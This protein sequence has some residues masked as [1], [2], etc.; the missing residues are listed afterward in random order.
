MD[1]TERYTT[2]SGR[3]YLIKLTYNEK[4]RDPEGANGFVQ[5]I[6]VLDDETKQ[7]V[8]VPVTATRFSTFEQ[9]SSFGSFCAINYQ[10]VRTAAIEGLRAKV[11]TRVEDTLERLQE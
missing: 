11:L 7:P 6:D 5:N 2:N 8:A 10:G 1:I 9:Y 3:R 4:I